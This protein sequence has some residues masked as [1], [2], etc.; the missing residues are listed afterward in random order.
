MFPDWSNLFLWLLTPF[1]P[2]GAEKVEKE[3]DDGLKR[4]SY[5][6]TVRG[7]E[8]GGEGE[9]EG[10]SGEEGDGGDVVR[11][12]E[13]NQ[14]SAVPVVIVES[15]GCECDGVNCV[16]GEG[17]EEVGPRPRKRLS[18]ILGRKSPS[19]SPQH[20]PGPQ[21]SQSSPNPQHPP[22]PQPSFE[23]PELPRPPTPPWPTEL[24]RPPDCCGEPDPALLQP[25][26][27]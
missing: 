6:S 27:P 17:E 23:P 20:P 26:G 2:R 13:S 21:P 10:E 11:D 4:C 7:G 22:G 8:M 3:E 24:L 5:Y 15:P 18:A 1:N 16:E 14:H 12:E 19:Q 9:G 25:P